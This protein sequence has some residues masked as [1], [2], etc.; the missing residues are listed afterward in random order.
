M[1]E[2]RASLRDEPELIAIELELRGDDIEARALELV[3]LEQHARERR[4]AGTRSTEQHD[5]FAFA[6]REIYS[7][8]QHA[9]VG[10]RD[11]QAANRE[12]CHH[13]RRR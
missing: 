8:D 4:L 7:V 2:Q 12:R 6:D 5:D 3:A 13:R 10:K 1:I 11:A 9:P